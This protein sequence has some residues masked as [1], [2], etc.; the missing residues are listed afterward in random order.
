MATLPE[1][2]EID[3]FFVFLNKK[4]PFWFQI[5]ILRWILS[6]EGPFVKTYLSSFLPY[7]IFFAKKR[8]CRTS[9]KRFIKTLERLEINNWF[10]FI[11]F[12]KVWPIFSAISDICFIRLLQFF[13]IDKTINIE[14]FL[15]YNCHFWQ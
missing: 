14:F 7:V 11:E 1:I 4:A 13:K 9:L 5:W 12:L 15:N 3:A 6:L 10:F 8:G 2:L